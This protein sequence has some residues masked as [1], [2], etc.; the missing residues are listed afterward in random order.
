MRLQDRRFIC[1]R[2]GTGRRARLRCVWVTM[3]VQ[4]P[5]TAPKRKADLCGLLF[6]FAV[7]DS[8]RRTPQIAE[9]SCGRKRA[10]AICAIRRQKAAV[11]RSTVPPTAPKRKADLSGCVLSG[12]MTDTQNFGRELFFSADW[13][14]N[15]PNEKP[16][17]CKGRCRANAWRRDCKCR[18]A[19][20]NNPSVANATAPFTQGSLWTR[21]CIFRGMGFA[22]CLC[23]TKA[24][25]AII[26]N[27]K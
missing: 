10:W 9:D 14:Y 23:N 6:L 22:L 26:E 11:C 20:K 16:H 13:C 3:G 24:K 21:S 15:E 25:L 18:K 1:G 17:L 2:G 7:A 19:A 12:E 5:P 4:V 27:E 8:R